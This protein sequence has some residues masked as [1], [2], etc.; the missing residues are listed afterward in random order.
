MFKAR[1]P[2]QRKR[3]AHQQQQK[4]Q[5]QQQHAGEFF[6]NKKHRLWVLF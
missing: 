1:E 2:Q 6:Q 5:R 3:D 4:R